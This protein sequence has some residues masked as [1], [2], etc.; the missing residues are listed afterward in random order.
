MPSSS[1][2]LRAAG[3]ALT[4]SLASAAVAA[5]SGGAIHA[6]GIGSTFTNCTVSGN[7]SSGTGGAVFLLESNSTFR[8]C[9]A[10][11]NAPAGLTREKRLRHTYEEAG[12]SIVYAVPYQLRQL[13]LRGDLANRDL[14]AVRQLSFGGEQFA[15]G[16]LAELARLLPSAELLNVY[17]PA[18]VNGVT[19]QHWPAGEE[20]IDDVPIG[21]AWP[22]VHLR[23]VDEDLEPV[24]DGEAGELL[25]ASAAQMVG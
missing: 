16:V 17:G 3:L 18:E 8:N 23:I 5:G 24:P 1:A 14:S 9:L 15:P 11:N 6:R 21:S 2:S 19:S 7:W 22:D 25:V 10:W 20:T 13:A 12:V 4:G